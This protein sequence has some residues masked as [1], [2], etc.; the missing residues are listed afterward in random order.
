MSGIDHEF[1]D[2]IVCPWCGHETGDSF[3]FQNDYGE[4]TCYECDKEFTY[5][6][7]IS[8]EYSTE[9]KEAASE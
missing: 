1:T 2:E 6:R 7:Y 5:T 4:E 3:E 9:K 8:V